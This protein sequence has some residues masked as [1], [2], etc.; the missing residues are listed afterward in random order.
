[1]KNLNIIGKILMIFSIIAFVPSNNSEVSKLEKIKSEKSLV[2]TTEIILYD[3]E[4]FE[5]LIAFRKKSVT[6]FDRPSIVIQDDFIKLLFPL[7]AISVGLGVFTIAFSI[8]Q[9]LSTIFVNFT[10]KIKS[11]PSSILIKI[12][13]LFP[14]RHRESIIQEISDMR[15]EYYEALSEKKIWRAKCI[16]AFYYVGLGWSVVMWISDKA[17]EVVGL[18][19]KKN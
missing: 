5:D 15:L 7:M 16:V 2:S 8:F 19:P 12:A 10:N 1:M 13:D 6:V 14:K 18:L 4:D 9:F 17:K 11:P 3:K